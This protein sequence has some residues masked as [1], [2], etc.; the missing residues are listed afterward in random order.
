MKSS[1]L[2]KLNWGAQSWNNYCLHPH[3][4]ST[5]YHC[6]HSVPPP[7]NLFVLGNPGK[8]YCVH[9]E[10]HLHIDTL[11]SCH[12]YFSP[13]RIFIIKQLTAHQSIITAANPAFHSPLVKQLTFKLTLFLFALIIQRF[14]ASISVF[15]PQWW[16]HVI[17]YR[18]TLFIAHLLN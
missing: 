12:I 8:D 17:I 4:T 13:S 10:L 5:S 1:S 11:Y 18:D 16:T 14:S 15:D 2:K 9:T 3:N 7:H 6:C